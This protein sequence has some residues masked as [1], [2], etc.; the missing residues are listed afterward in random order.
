[1]KTIDWDKQFVDERMVGREYKSQR[2]IPT[3]D[4]WYPCFFLDASGKEIVHCLGEQWETY[5]DRRN[6]GASMVLGTVYL[7][8]R[9]ILNNRCFVRVH[10]WGND[11]TGI[12][13]DWYCDTVEEGL[14]IYDRWVKWLTNLS[15]ACRHELLR[16][17]FH[18]A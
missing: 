15:V 3:A 7:T 6:K 5:E 4:D 11:D 17:G 10:L 12:E 16:L 18:N 2:Y 9:R 13:Q 1:M 8:H 14:A